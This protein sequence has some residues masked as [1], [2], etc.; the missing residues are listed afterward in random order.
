MVKAIRGKLDQVISWCMYGY[1]GWCTARYLLALVPVL[2][3]EAVVGDGCI[4]RTA[5]FFAGTGHATHVNLFAVACLALPDRPPEVDE[6]TATAGERVA[7]YCGAKGASTSSRLAL[8]VVRVCLVGEFVR[9][10]F[11]P[12][13]GWWLAGWLVVRPRMALSWG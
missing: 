9:W 10:F 1:A 3:T 12:V 13:V 4:M 2:S 11:R 5:S 8:V 7:G 6:A